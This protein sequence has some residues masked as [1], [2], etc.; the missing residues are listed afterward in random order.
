MIVLVID[1]MY[2][3][4]F[5][6]LVKMIYYILLGKDVV[7]V[8]ELKFFCYRIYSIKIIILIFIW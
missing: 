8:L 5:L 4:L 7:L 6:L 2:D 1:I 3:L